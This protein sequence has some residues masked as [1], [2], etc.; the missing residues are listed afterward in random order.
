[1]YVGRRGHRNAPGR[2]VCCLW[3]M[4]SATLRGGMGTMS[5]GDRT[6]LAHSGVSPDTARARPG[7]LHTLPLTSPEGVSTGDETE[8]VVTV[9]RGKRSRTTDLAALSVCRS[10]GLR[11]HE[12]AVCVG[13]PP[14]PDARPAAR[15]TCIPHSE[16]TAT[17]SLRAIRSAQPPPRA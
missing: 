15:H 8:V 4:L 5:R 9:Y 12:S 17:A 7:P 1:M 2:W 10:D 14:P 16:E 13:R 6:A 11:P 3:R